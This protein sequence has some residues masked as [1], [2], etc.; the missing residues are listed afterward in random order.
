VNHE[1]NLN[2]ALTFS[3][4]ELSEILKAMKTDTTPGPDGFPVDFFPEMMAAC[5]TRGF[6][7]SKRFHPRED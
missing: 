6:T 5:E 2:L 7:Y 4:A 1:E 3:K